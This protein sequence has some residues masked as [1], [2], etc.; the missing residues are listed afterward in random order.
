MSLRLRVG[1]LLLAATLLGA[2]CATTAPASGGAAA[3]V[4]VV[5]PGDPFEAFNRKVFAF[6]DTIDRAVLEPVA[7]AY[8]DTVPE[9]VRTGIS[10]LLGNIGDVWSAANQF[11]QGKAQLGF[12]M[13]MRV[14]T[15]TFFGLGGL[16]DPA[17]EM[18]LT[19]RSEDFG[20]TLGRWGFGP[21]PYVM[22]PFLGPSTLRDTSGRL[23]DSQASASQLPSSEAARAAVS[24]IQILDLRTSLLGATALLDSVALDRYSF[25]RDAYLQRRLDAVHDGAPPLLEDPGDDAPEPEPAKASAEAPK[26]AAA[27][28]S[29]AGPKP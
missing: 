27:P 3:K 26:P 28:P 6:N 24:A 16:L 15:N 18:G 9:L 22:L 21:G 5:T 23:L 29:K 13:S 19:R 10:N 2:G 25:V 1:G 11:L 7:K 12:E 14:M 8:R 17:S 4:A 20:Q